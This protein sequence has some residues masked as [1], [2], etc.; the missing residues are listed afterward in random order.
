MASEIAK[1]IQFLSDEKGLEYE[2]VLEALEIALAAAYRKDFGT[3]IGNYHVKFDADTGDM[4]IWDEKIVVEDVDE[5]LLEKAQEELT[6]LR[7]KAR[8]EYR[9][10]TEEGTAHLPQ[11][12]PKT[13]I[14]LKDAKEV[15]KNAKLGDTLKIQQTVPGD[16]GRMAAMTAKQVIIQKIREAERNNVF[17]DFKEQVGQIVQGTV[18]KRD[19]GGNVLVDL[20]KITGVLSAEEQVRREQ[21]RPGIRLPFFI[22]SI[23]MGPRGPQIELSRKSTKMVQSVFEQEIPEIDEGSVEIKAIARDPGSRSKVAVFTDDNSIDPIGA[24]IGQ[25]GSRITTIIDELGG[26]KIDV[27]MWSDNAEEF[28]KQALS[29]AKVASVELNEQTKEAAVSVGEDQFSLAIGRGGQN[30]RLAAELTGWR[31]TVV[32]DGNEKAVAVSSEDDEDAIKEKLEADKKESEEKKGDDVADVSGDTDVENDEVA[33]I[34]TEEGKEET[35]E[36]ATEEKDEEK[37]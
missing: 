33:E 35:V 14:M 36:E 22:M 23:E 4:D 5:E 20:G 30:V 10:L 12:N 8:E 9:E 19:R 34:T 3:K 21:Y 1:A 7:E 16:F 26:E 24:C 32:E 15:E 29:P 2:E 6:A 27:I 28:I 13:D 25:R 18:H 17:E 37:K 31:I 11:F